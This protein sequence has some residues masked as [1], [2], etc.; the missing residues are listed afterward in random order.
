MEKITNP[1]EIRFTATS[2]ST[3]LPSPTAT[4]YGTTTTRY[5]LYKSVCADGYLR[6]PPYR[7]RLLPPPGGIEQRRAPRPGAST[8]R[9]ETCTGLGS[10]AA[11]LLAGPSRSRAPGRTE[12][13]PA[14]AFRSGGCW[15]IHFMY[16]S[17]VTSKSPRSRPCAHA[18]VFVCAG[19][20]RMAPIVV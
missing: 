1:N 18:F 13:S 17:V 9:H 6:C 8:R 5:G 7:Q 19:S 16:R 10:A 20:K 2:I 14:P 3:L 4:R 11:P 12:P 15:I